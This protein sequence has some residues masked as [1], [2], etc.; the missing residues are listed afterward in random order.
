MKKVLLFGI[1]LLLTGCST[2]VTLKIDSENVS[3]II[4]ISELKSVAFPNN[5]LNDDIKSNMEVFEREYEFYDMNEFENQDY[6][7]KTYEF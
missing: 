3:E 5:I 7:N 2:E 4:K 6:V 1:L